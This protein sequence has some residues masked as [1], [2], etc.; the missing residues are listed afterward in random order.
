MELT[1]K[2]LK[3]FK[4][5]VQTN[6]ET[7]K[8]TSKQ[9]DT[10]LSYTST[11]LN[12]LQEKGMINLQRHGNTKKPTVADTTHAETLRTLILEQPNYDIEFLA[13]RG[14]TILA[15]IQCQNLETLEEI[16]EASGASYRT[17][18]Q[19]MEKTR[20][21]GIIQ[22]KNTYYIGPSHP[23]IQAFVESYTGYTNLRK[24]KRHASDAV[25]KWSCPKEY[26]F[27][28]EAKLNL[29]ATG[30]SAF[31]EYGALFYTT[32]N[33]YTSKKE[34]QSLED[35]L[36][37]HILSEGTRN[38]LPLLITWRL[39]KDKIDI[40]Y[41]KDKARR[42]KTLE[43]IEDIRTYLETEGENRANYLLNWNEF[44]AKYRDY[45]DE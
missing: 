42:L 10:P 8:E 19:Y 30:A 13:N 35:H 12:N 39:N 27:E 3:I 1:K 2:E 25:I 34:K 22:K 43:T 11:T 40:R 17:L 24:A 38:T 28:T 26:I 21:R 5:I 31:H 20:G 37:N 4:T 44:T 9:T 7:I 45:G 41:L 29:Q 33:L 18:W 14:T 23:Q 32:K 16:T 36:I 6:P 15:T